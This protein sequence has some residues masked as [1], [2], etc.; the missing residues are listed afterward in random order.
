MRVASIVLALAVSSLAVGNVLAEPGKKCARTI[1]P[2]H[3]AY[4]YAAG[5]RPVGPHG[6]SKG[7]TRGT[8]AG[9]RA[10]AQGDLPGQAGRLDP[11]AEAGPQ[12]RARRCEGGPRRRPEAGQRPQGHCRR[13]Q[14]SAEQKAKLAKLAKAAATLRAKVR[15]KALSILTP[16]QVAELKQSKK[17]HR[18]AHQ[19]SGSPSAPA[20]KTPADKPPAGQAPAERR[21]PD[22]EVSSRPPSR[23]AAA[24]RQSDKAGLLTGPAFFMRG[25]RVAV[26]SSAFI[27]VH[28]SNAT[29]V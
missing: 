14:P 16:E 5:H 9:I 7:E 26:R 28:K 20:E 22:S 24:S 2:E 1:R 27:D 29:S 25:G 21:Q 6:R 13:G 15:E 18:K 12:R 11:R 8:E 17:T 4:G 10:E 19:A 23:R 3:R